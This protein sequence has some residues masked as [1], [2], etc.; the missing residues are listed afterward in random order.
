[1]RRGS[2]GVSLSAADPEE[3]GELA[4]LGYDALWVSGGRMGSLDRIAEI[5][6]AT[7]RVPVATGIVPLGVYEPAAVAALHHELSVSHPH[8]L[9]LG[10][11]GPQQRRAL[12]ALHGCLDDLDGLGVGAA[13]RLIA[14]LGPRKL[15][16]ARDRS[17]GAITL[18]VTPES[19]ASA[20]RALGPDA[21]LAVHQMAVLE[22]DAGRARAVARPT[23]EFLSRVGGYRS[24]FR[25]MGFTDGE[26][27]ALAPRLVDAVV[28]W[29]DE[30]EI[31]A[32]LRAQQDAGADQVVLSVLSAGGSVVEEARALAR[33]LGVLPAG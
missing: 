18:L 21:L 12:A 20:R 10:L 23:L 3:A 13:D 31:A 1:V 2:I 19:T 27:D 8:R 7:E 9:V 4:R 26:V 11:G 17:A 24:S 6:R 25:R 22:A 16:L 30:D 32:R 14:A 5:V 15:E 33:P 28:A 29:G